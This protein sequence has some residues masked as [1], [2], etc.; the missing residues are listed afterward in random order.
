MKTRTAILSTLGVLVM[1]QT[2]ASADCSWIAWRRAFRGEPSQVWRTEAGFQDAEDCQEFLT[3]MRDDSQRR[4]MQG[5]LVR[6]TQGRSDNEE[7]SHWLSLSD[8]NKTY[9]FGCLP[10]GIIPDMIWKR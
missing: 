5:A 3:N 2:V 8:K 7:V 10:M 4:G 6:V 9:W 1:A